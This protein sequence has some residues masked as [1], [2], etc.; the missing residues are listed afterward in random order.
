MHCSA[1]IA[2][3]GLGSRMRAFKPTMALNHETMIERLIRVFREAGVRE[4]VVVAGHRAE[5]L[6]EHIRP[7]GVTWCVNRDYATTEMFDSIRLG[8]RHLTLPYD[9]VFVTPVDIPLVRVETLRA[10]Q[11]AEGDVIRPRWGGKSGHPILLAASVVDKMMD[12]DGTDG[13]RGAI[14]AL[15]EAMVDLPVDDRAVLLDADTPEA[16]RRL[17]AYEADREDGSL[18]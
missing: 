2:A 12:Y 17:R 11:R 10:L 5:E 18:A 8:C 14:Y 3:A 7:Y 1:V 6:A 16:Y 15:S 13:L 9:R 4:T